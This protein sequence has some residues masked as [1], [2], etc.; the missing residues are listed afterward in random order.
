MSVLTISIVCTFFLLIVAGFAYWYYYYYKKESPSPTL[1]AGSSLSAR[2][3]LN[4]SASRSPPGVST[5]SFSNQTVNPDVNTAITTV[6]SVPTNGVPSISDGNPLQICIKRRKAT[7][8]SSIFL[9]FDTTNNVINVIHQDS[10]TTSTECLFYLEKVSN[11]AIGAN[12]SQ[13]YKIYAY[14]ILP[15]KCLES[16]SNGNLIL[17][18]EATNNR[19]QVF[20]FKNGYMRNSGTRI[21]NYLVELYSASTSGVRNSIIAIT[22]FQIS[23]SDNGVSALASTLTATSDQPINTT[24][25]NTVYGDRHS[26]SLSYSAPHYISYEYPVSDTRFY[27]FNSLVWSSRQT[28]DTRKGRN[29]PFNLN[30]GAYVSTPSGVNT[31]IPPFRSS[32]IFYYLDLDINSTVPS[33]LIVYVKPG[34]VVN[35][36]KW[37]GTTWGTPLSGS[38][39]D[40]KSLFYGGMGTPVATFSNNIF[41]IDISITKRSTQFRFDINNED[42]VSDY[43]ISFMFLDKDNEISDMGCN[44]LSNN[45]KIVTYDQLMRLYGDQISLNKGVNE[46]LYV[47]SGTNGQGSDNTSKHTLR[48]RNGGCDSTNTFQELF[49]YDFRT[50][51]IQS[52]ETDGMCL[53]VAGTSGDPGTVNWD[54]EVI[55]SFATQNYIRGA[56]CA[57]NL[58][59]SRWNYPEF[60]SHP[61]FN[62]IQSVNDTNLFMATEL[63]S[64]DPRGN[65]MLLWPT[66]SSD[67]SSVRFSIG[68]VAPSTVT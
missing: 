61:G 67:D 23:S 7:N 36:Y 62:T 41:V 46:C 9:S 38:V 51:Q 2:P 8:G 29:S 40:S 16:T 48:M 31:P 42:E 32:S 14:G 3:S 28:G 21:F 19:N 25:F 35:V 4:P 47:G 49:L 20:Y 52:T 17:N 43:G 68:L 37:S 60:N 64:W 10:T 59:S 30:G 1:S 11:S 57:L 65:E 55:S 26:V 45:N 63:G 27:T 18:S 33:K 53:A 66:P 22:D 12:S 15:K 44:E 6:N 50:K 24:N 39:I 5:T 13:A 54:G 34:C 56:P 58:A